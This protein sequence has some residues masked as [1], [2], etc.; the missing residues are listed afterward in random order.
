DEAAREEV[1]VLRG[2]LA[3]GPGG[4]PDDLRAVGREERAAVVAE[5]ARE[6]YRL[7]GLHVVAPE[8]EVAGARRGEDDVAAV[9][10][11]GGLGVVAGATDEQLAVRTI[12]IGDVDVVGRVDGP[13]VD[14]GGVRRWCRALRPGGVGR[15]VDDAA[16][17]EEVTA[18]R[19]A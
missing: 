1:T 11:D 15:G 18:R 3:F 9:R 14:A 2:G 4:A 7:L 13:G 6:L 19:P 10:A 16:V 8:V 17:G 12:A 5:V